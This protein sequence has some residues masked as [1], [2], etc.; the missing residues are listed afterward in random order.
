LTGGGV[1]HVFL[2]VYILCFAAGVTLIAVAIFAAV[3]YGSRTLRSFAL[4]FFSSTL[5]MIVEALKTYESAT[6]SDFGPGLHVFIA[7]VS[8]AANA[9]MGWLLPLVAFRLVG[10]ETSAARRASHG[11][12]AGLLGCLGGLKEYVAPLVLWNVDF[13]A[14]LGLHVY[15]ALILYRGL[16]HVADPWLKSLLR[17]VLIFISVFAP[18]SVVQL[19]LTDL[20]S[21][22][23]I[24]KSYPLEELAYY[25]G[26]VILILVYF[27]AYRFEASSG[28]VP[29]FSQESMQRYGISHR[30]ADIISM[31]AQGY[32]NGEIAKRLFISALTVKNHV[33]HIY[34]KTGAGNKVQLLNLMN[35]PK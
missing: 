25:L 16:R 7:A 4:L 20:P 8:I 10:R 17:S 27:S 13:I 26:F 22:P 15:G 6:R 34:Q 23:Q 9:G 28:A 14:L 24:V 31:M 29:G 3:R 11:V 5:L 19:V 32:S 21:G 30:E 1:P 33:Y 12:T 2:A 18:L 35:S